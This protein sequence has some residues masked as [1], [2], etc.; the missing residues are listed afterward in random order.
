MKQRPSQYCI[1]CSTEYLNYCSSTCQFCS[2]SQENDVHTISFENIQG[3]LE[4]ASLHSF[5]Y[6]FDLLCT[7]IRSAD[8]QERGLVILFFFTEQN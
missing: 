6:G 5:S 2:I 7:K 4:F 1:I 3:L 8:F